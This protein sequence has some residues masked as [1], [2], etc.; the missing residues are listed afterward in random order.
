MQKLQKSMVLAALIVM[1]GAGGRLGRR[2]VPRHRERLLVTIPE[3]L[4][5]NLAAQQIG[6]GQ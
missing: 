3:A 5:A 6:V 4:V 2:N 1:V